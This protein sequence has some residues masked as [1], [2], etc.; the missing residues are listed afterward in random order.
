VDPFAC[1]VGQFDGE[2]RRRLDTDPKQ[3]G[4]DKRV[5]TGGGAHVEGSVQVSGGD[6]VGRGQYVY[7]RSEREELDDY[8]AAVTVE[9]ASY[10]GKLSEAIQTYL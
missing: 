5:D 10:L 1:D 3:K 2:G 9:G 8:L 4:E 7:S 6:S